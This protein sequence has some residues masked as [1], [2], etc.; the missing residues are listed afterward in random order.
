MQST[1]KRAFVLCF[2]PLRGYAL[3]GVSKTLCTAALTKQGFGHTHRRITT[4]E[5][6][7][8]AGREIAAIE[9]ILRSR[10]STVTLVHGEARRILSQLRARKRVAED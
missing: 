9:S 7:F 1:G 10:H 4:A 3:G 2:W 5:Q 8:R 6:I